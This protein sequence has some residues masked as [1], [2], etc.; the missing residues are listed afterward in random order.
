MAENDI[1]LLDDLDSTD[2]DM[3]DSDLEIPNLDEVSALDFDPSDDIDYLSGLNL[4]DDEGSH[5]EGDVESF[6]GEKDKNKNFFKKAVDFVVN[7]V[8]TQK[9]LS[10]AI[11]S[12]I[13][14]LIVF[15][16]LISVLTSK[17]KKK[18]EIVPAEKAAELPYD[19]VLPM[20]EI[21]DDYT[22]SRDLKDR[23]TVEEGERW[24]EIPDGKMMK[25]LEDKNSENVNE[26]LE[27]VP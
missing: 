18:P 7:F 1:D 27:A 9:I 12:L 16:V 25:E 24:F 23:W 6:S 20:S 26:I 11:G 4:S 21:L 17:G 15:V 3:D 2:F 8:K 19:Y 5:I 10:I 14:L 22:F 13:L